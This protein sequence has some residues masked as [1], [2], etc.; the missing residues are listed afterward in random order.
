MKRFTIL[1]C[2]SCTTYPPPE[3]RR[4]NYSLYEYVDV[5]M[6]EFLNLKFDDEVCRLS[7]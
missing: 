2:P 3:V 1:R 5:W 6:L 4:G 7:V